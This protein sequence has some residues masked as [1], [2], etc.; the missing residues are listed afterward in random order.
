MLENLLTASLLQSVQERG[1]RDLYR[2]LETIVPSIED[3]YSLAK[4]K[5]RFL[6]TKVRAQQT[7]QIA[8]IW[9]A[10]QL[11][12]RNSGAK[13][14]TVVDIGDSSG[15][16]SLYLQALNAGLPL[17]LR[18]VS[19]NLDKIAIEKVKSKGLN[20]IHCHA[21]DLQKQGINA[22]VYVCLQ[23]LEHLTNPIGF[24]RSL[25]VNGN[26]EYFVITVP[27]VPQSRVAL[28]NV[29]NN[30]VAQATPEETHIFEF[31]PDDW[32]PIFKLSGWVPVKTDIFLQYPKHHPLRA[33]RR[34]WRRGD[35]E[36]FYGVIL[37][38][39]RKFLDA[40]EGWS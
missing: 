18:T 33:T 3:Q 13:A 38:K 36:G 28:P 5:G 37:K 19:V 29:R 6:A 15:T 12:Q 17:E 34:F 23:T 2:R 32:E 8:L 27:Y 30:S 11:A 35:F 9:E 14:L 10:L 24:L 25:S 7:F 40:F 20:A 39:D 22:D 31:S 4:I 21:E 1:Q 26:A 16:H